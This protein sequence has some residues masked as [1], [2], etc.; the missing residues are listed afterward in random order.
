MTSTSKSILIVGTGALAC[1][2][3]ARFASV[4]LP[5]FMLGNWPE[6]V[7]VLRE[8]GV[9]L[10]ETDG[11]ESAYPVQ[12]IDSNDG[13]R[14]FS[15]VLVLVKSWQTERTAKQLVQCLLPNSH[16]LIMQNGLGNREV[17][18][19]YFGD[20]NVFTGVT[21]IGAAL[22]GPGRVQAGGIGA[23]SLIDNL[24]ELVQECFNI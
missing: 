19:S 12:V 2:F 10:I 6:G 4:G 22:L 13:C 15:N 21:T 11:C 1:L 18:A 24:F 20:E 8:T 14:Q 9:H 23:I 3:A 17:F 7:R 5:A 16:V